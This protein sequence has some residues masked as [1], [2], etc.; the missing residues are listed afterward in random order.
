MVIV[1]FHSVYFNEG[2]KYS[3]PPPTM[4]Y[5][6]LEWI[7]VLLQHH[8]GG[9]VKSFPHPFLRGWEAG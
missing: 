5:S 2:K 8:H 6:Q 4:S 9:T 1:K 3:V 7:D